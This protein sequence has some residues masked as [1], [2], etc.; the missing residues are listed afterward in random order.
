MLSNY[1]IHSWKDIGSKFLCE[2]NN[3]QII[4]HGE[5][6]VRGKVWCPMG[7]AG[8]AYRPHQSEECFWLNDCHRFSIQ[9]LN[10]VIDDKTFNK[11]L[12]KIKSYSEE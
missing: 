3:G 2:K 10:T 7:D 9:E 8:T 5:Y 12:S 11:H 1:F 4:I 6:D